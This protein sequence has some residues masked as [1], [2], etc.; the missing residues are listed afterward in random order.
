MIDR[1]SRVDS[2]DQDRASNKITHATDEASRKPTTSAPQEDSIQN[3]PAHRYAQPWFFNCLGRNAWQWF[4]QV[5]FKLLEGKKVCRIQSLRRS[6]AIQTLVNFIRWCHRYW[7]IQRVNG[8]Y[9]A[10][11]YSRTRV[12]LPFKSD[13]SEHDLIDILSS[14]LP[15]PHNLIGETFE[16]TFVYYPAQREGVGEWKN[17]RLHGVDSVF[18]INDVLAYSRISVSLLYFVNHQRP[19]QQWLTPPQPL[20]KKTTPPLRSPDSP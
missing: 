13:L 1:F 14:Y 11:I 15:F 12:Y 18:Y 4:A 20:T 17:P 9:P 7:T 6:M 3:Q 8:R 10:S 19:E 16:P 2:L 5:Y